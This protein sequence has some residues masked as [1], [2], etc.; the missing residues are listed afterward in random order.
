[1]A[2]ELRIAG[3]AQKRIEGY[4]G[5]FGNPDPKPLADAIEEGLDELAEDPDLGQ[6]LSEPFGRPIYRF[7][8]EAVDEEGDP[9]KHYLQVAYRVGESD[10]TLTILDFS[11][12][13]F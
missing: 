8:V 4:V 10:S 3:H 1:M 12:I 2:Y 13:P 6:V 7:A 5:Q 11:A 9:V